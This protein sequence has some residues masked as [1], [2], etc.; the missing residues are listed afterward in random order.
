VKTRATRRADAVEQG[1]KTR[2]VKVYR[3]AC[4]KV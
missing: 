3:D 2:A 4:V 1:M